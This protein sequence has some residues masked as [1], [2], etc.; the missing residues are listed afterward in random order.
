MG[1]LGLKPGV[2]THNKSALTGGTPNRSDALLIGSFL[3]RKGHLSLDSRFP[4]PT[5]SR[6]S[7]LPFHKVFQESK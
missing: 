7:L 3:P 4:L 5:R 2:F 6:Y 1:M